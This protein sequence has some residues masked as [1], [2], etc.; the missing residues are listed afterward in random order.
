MVWHNGVKQPPNCVATK[1]C[2]FIT[3]SLNFLICKAAVTAP[4]EQHCLWIKGKNALLRALCW[5]LC[6][7]LIH[8]SCSSYE[9]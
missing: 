3:L 6:K 1:L 7:L 4:R 9:G 5:A 2:D 8:A